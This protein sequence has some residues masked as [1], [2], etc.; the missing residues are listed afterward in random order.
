VIGNLAKSINEPLVKV[1]ARKAH[2]RATYQASLEDA[3]DLRNTS[4][5]VKLQSAFSRRRTERGVKYIP[6]DFC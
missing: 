6:L 2:K 5:Q 4:T 3:I 1:V